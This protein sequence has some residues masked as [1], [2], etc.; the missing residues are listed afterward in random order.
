MQLLW[1]FRGRSL[2]EHLKM[3]G[4][5]SVN[6][7]PLPSRSEI[8]V[9]VVRVLSKLSFSSATSLIALQKSH[10]ARATAHQT[11][12][13]STLA[14]WKIRMMSPFWRQRT[15]WDLS[16]QVLAFL[17]S[18]NLAA[19]AYF[20]MMPCWSS[21]DASD[22]VADPLA[23]ADARERFAVGASVGGRASLD[24]AAR[25]RLRGPRAGTSSPGADD[26]RWG[27]GDEVSQSGRFRT[28]PEND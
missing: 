25:R 13:P 8:S 11:R 12:E 5:D 16:S 7:R 24:C 21:P 23:E 10:L 9:I 18:V 15:A 2:L 22:G 14:L 17:P 19:C 3:K 28:V 4:E 1:L 6:V 20:R 27:P 26:M